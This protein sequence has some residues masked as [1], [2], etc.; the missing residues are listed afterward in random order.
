MTETVAKSTIE[1]RN[2]YWPENYGFLFS[3]SL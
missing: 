2:P 3:G 1:K